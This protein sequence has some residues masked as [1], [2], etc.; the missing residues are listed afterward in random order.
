MTKKQK[1]LHL[2]ISYIIFVQDN[3]F[4]RHEINKKCYFMKS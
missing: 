2:L 3:I 4:L 1:N